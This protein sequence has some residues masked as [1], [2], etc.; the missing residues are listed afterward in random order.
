MKRCLASTEGTE[1]FMIEL[2]DIHKAYQMGPV[3][4]EVLKGVDL[5]IATGELLSIVGQSGCG[6]STLMN[7]I[8]LLD[9][10]CSGSYILDGAPVDQM[11]DSDLSEIRNRNIGF[12]FQQF[13][14]LSK[15]TALQ[16]VA[17]PLVYRGT[18][19]KMR[20]QAA[21]EVLDRVGM[22]DRENHRP[23]EL[24]GGQ[25]QRVAIAR[26]I[27]GKPAI[28]L[29]DEPTGALDEKVGQ[30][31]MDLFIRL[32]REESITV[33]VI[34]HDMSI[35]RQCNGYVRM[36]DGGINDNQAKHH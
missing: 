23:T 32:N 20:I 16:N 4:V 5:T 28:I 9:S 30:E 12:V 1:I 21:R 13:N 11:S 29:A 33:F 10:A 27:V 18:S 26:A 15:L 3:S 35:A 2:K 22:L 19:E 36:R 31:I 6:K 8:G 14:L 17:L 7:I 24:S 34:T 25:Q